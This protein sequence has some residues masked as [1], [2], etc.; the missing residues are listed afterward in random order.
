LLIDDATGIV[1][2]R[3]SFEDH[4]GPNGWRASYKIV[5][6][7]ELRDDRMAWFATGPEA[8]AFVESGTYCRSYII[9]RKRTKDE[10]LR[11]A[12]VRVGP[13]TL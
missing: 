10:I 11:H 8:K 7:N 2:G 4:S 9:E 13:K 12:G 5:D 6:M 1:V 3:I